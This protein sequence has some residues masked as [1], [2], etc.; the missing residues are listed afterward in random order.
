MVAATNDFVSDPIGYRVED[1]ATRRLFNVCEALGVL[2]NNFSVLY[3]SNG[4]ARSP[5]DFLDITY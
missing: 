2:E 4:H 1:S 5:A 3:H